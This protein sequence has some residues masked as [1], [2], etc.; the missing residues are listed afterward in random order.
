M[1]KINFQIYKQKRKQRVSVLGFSPRVDWVF[2][3]LTG[4]ILIVVG[5]IYAGWL[6]IKVNN[7]SLFE[8]VEDTASQT[9]LEK[10]KKEIDKAVEI[11]SKE[12]MV[13]MP[14][15]ATSTVATTT[16]TTS[17]PSVQ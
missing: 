15:P 5:I 6:Y 14:L 2:I 11:F 12:P 10:Q 8:I 16:V 13:A 3:W 9:E 17:I 4:I 7:G 1:K